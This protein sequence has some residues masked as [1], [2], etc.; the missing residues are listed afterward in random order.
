MWA[1]V[2]W[3]PEMPLTVTENSSF[4]VASSKTRRAKPEPGPATGGFSCAPVR[5][6]SIVTG[7]AC[8]TLPP[9]RAA[10][11]TSAASPASPRTEASVLRSFVVV[12]LCYKACQC[13]CKNDVNGTQKQGI[14]QDFRFEIVKTQGN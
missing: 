11:A 9:G 3:S 14:F 7:A 13:R 1:A 10:K 2:T 4:F 6:I 8:A 5:A 12:L